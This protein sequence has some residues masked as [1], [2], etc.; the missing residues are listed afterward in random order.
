LINRI[1][2]SRNQE[3]CGQLVTF[4]NNHNLILTAKSLIEFSAIDFK[5]EESFDV[6]FFGSIRA[7]DFFFKKSIINSNCEI[8][9]IGS[10]TAAKL[11]ERGIKVS[12]IGSHAGRPKVV[13]TEFKN[14]LGDRRVLIPHSSASLFSIVE[15][16]KPEQ[17]KTIEVYKTELKSVLIS[18]FDCYIFT[19]PSNVQ[20]FISS[21]EKTKLKNVIAWGKSTESE[22]LKNKIPASITLK[23]GTMIEL[24]NYLKT[25]I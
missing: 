5:I 22:L 10:E 9:C 16:L 11:S 23:T 25:I 21:N 12:F 18:E 15:F 2:I 17:Y 4:C 7:T 20:S 1:F 13:A 14:W 24:Q 3:D 8:A 6:I 19:S